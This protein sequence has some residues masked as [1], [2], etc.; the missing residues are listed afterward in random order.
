MEN[1]LNLIRFHWKECKLKA[2]STHTP[3][4]ALAITSRIR[5]AISRGQW[6]PWTAVSPLM[7]L[8]RMHSRQSVT[9]ENPCFFFVFQAPPATDPVVQWS[10]QWPND[11]TILNRARV[12]GLCRATSEGGYTST[13]KSPRNRTWPPG[14]VPRPTGHLSSR[15]C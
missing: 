5:T 9:G 14:N 10:V 4:H 11:I 2:R 6:Q 3:T 1:G 15:A 13:P 7:G 8:I 12:Q